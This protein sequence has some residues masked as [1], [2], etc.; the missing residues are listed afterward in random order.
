MGWT[1]GVPFPA[2]VDFLLLQM[3]STQPPVQWVPGLKQQGSE[4][5]SSPPCIAQVKNA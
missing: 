2:V 1:T 4:V 3:A 5:D